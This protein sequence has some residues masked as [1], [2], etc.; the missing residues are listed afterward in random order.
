MQTLLHLIY[1]GQLFFIACALVA[2]S[3]LLAITGALERS[4]LGRSVASVTTLSSIFAAAISGTP[5]ALVLAV[6]STAIVASFAT[7]GIVAP[8]KRRRVLSAL[9]I[10]AA[11]GCAASEARWHLAPTGDIPL[12]ARLIVLGDS[13]SSGGF[14]E[15]QPW[16]SIA[17]AQLG[18]KV[19]NLSM[20]GETASSA[21]QN[22]LPLLPPPER[23]DCV[24]VAVGGNDMLEG[25][26]SAAYEAALDSILASASSSTRPVVMLELPIVPGEWRFG[27]IQRSLARKHGVALVPKR[28]I[29]A[30]LLEPG[31]TSDGLH[32]TQQGHERL[33][34]EITRALGW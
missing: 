4:A 20:P 28:A 17:A 19:V 1:S 27:A 31:S 9:A 22:Q 21:M 16:P 25:H 30:V 13:L 18:A 14:G 7:F 23:G 26:P 3:A 32:P 2:V 24:V 5:V 11:V 33:A 6:G 10:A 29:A 15:S 8:L 12:P 34:A